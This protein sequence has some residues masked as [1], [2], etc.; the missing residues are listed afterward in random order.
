MRY[1]YQKPHPKLSAYIRNV[2]VLEGFMP[3]D[4][5]RVPLFTNGMPAF[6]CRTENVD[7]HQTQV[8]SL[9]LFGQST[10]ND[11]WSLTENTT[12]IAYF[13]KP[14]ALGTLFNIA[15]SK[16]VKFPI[17]LHTWNVHQVNALRTQLGYAQSTDRK[18]AALDHLLIQLLEEN[19]KVCEAIQFA[20]DHIMENSNPEVL[21]DVL[22]KLN[23]NTRTFQRIFKKY[24]G[25]TSSQYRRICQFQ[26]SFSQLRTGKFDSLTDVAFDNGFSDQSHFIRSFKEYTDTTPND[27]LKSGLNKKKP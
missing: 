2:L 19:K 25:V 18:V 13:F 6:Y 17:D 3:A 5:T 12:V 4:D 14:F 10:S 1:R 21:S 8:T 9:T 22:T 20:T 27:Y 16:L 24:V 26:L 23:I 15:A 7:E 11:C